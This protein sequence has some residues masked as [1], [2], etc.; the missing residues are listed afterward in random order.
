MYPHKWKGYRAYGEGEHAND[1]NDGCFTQWASQS[2]SGL[3]S[4][5]VRLTS[6]LKIRVLIAL[7]IAGCQN[8]YKILQV[9]SERSSF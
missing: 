5:Y 9:V 4:W 7:H 8:I 1:I 6:V 3:L 2:P